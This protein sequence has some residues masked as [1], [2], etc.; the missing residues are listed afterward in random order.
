M[1]FSYLNACRKYAFF[2]RVFS[3]RKFKIWNWN[4]AHSERQSLVYW[5]MI[6]FFQIFYSWNKIWLVQSFCHPKMADWGP[7][8]IAWER[9]IGCTHCLPSFNLTNNCCGDGN[10]T[11]S[12]P[13]ISMQPTELGSFW[14]T[15]ANKYRAVQVAIESTSKIFFALHLVEL[16]IFTA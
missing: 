14:A 7:G 16:E 13:A 12:V 6:N 15:T 8:R 2:R 9:L 1:E 3:W 11:F 5:K 4:F 10:T